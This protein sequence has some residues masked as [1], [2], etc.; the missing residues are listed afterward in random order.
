MHVPESTGPAVVCGCSSHPA[1]FCLCPA[2]ASTLPL[3]FTSHSSDPSYHP[4]LTFGVDEVIV[5]YHSSS[6]SSYSFLRKPYLLLS[7][8]DTLDAFAFREPNRCN[9]SLENLTEA[10]TQQS[11]CRLPQ[12]ARVSPR[13]REPSLC[14][15]D[16]CFALMREYPRT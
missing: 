4:A 13:V 10:L 8:T 6:F 15:Q 14:A 1:L 2:K 7:S 9:G 3:C 16:V 11:H 12:V 5:P